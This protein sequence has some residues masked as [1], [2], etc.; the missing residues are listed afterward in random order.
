MLILL[1]NGIILNAQ[2]K[3]SKQETI[4]WITAKIRENPRIE[5]L[6]HPGVYYT[7]SITDNDQIRCSLI[8]QRKV[9]FTSTLTFS[10]NDIC[11]ASFHENS[12]AIN[13]T[14]KNLIKSKSDDGTTDE[15]D[16][17]T[18]FINPNAAPNMPERMLKAFKT[19]AEYNC[20]KVKEVY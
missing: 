11:S 13:V 18:F 14:F 7:Y 16:S 12:K 8:S 9:S 20:P 17:W 4:D 1:L 2:T 15:E 19:L 5:D 3:P 10:F 6:R